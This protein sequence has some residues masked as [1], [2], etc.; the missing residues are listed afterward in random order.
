MSSNHYSKSHI[1]QV[2]KMIVPILIVAAIGLAIADVFGADSFI[3][4]MFFKKVVFTPYNIVGIILFFLFLG[5]TWVGKG[6]AKVMFGVATV[7]SIMPTLIKINNFLQ[8]D[9]AAKIFDF[10]AIALIVV[11]GLLFIIPIIVVIAESICESKEEKKQK[12]KFIAKK[13]NSLSDEDLMKHIS[14]NVENKKQQTSNS[15]VKQN[16]SLGNTQL[17]QNTNY[18]TSCIRDSD[19]WKIANRICPRCGAKL[20]ARTNGHDGTHFLGCTK[21]GKTGCD[22]TINY[23][24]Y[25]AIQERL[26]IK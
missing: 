17:I 6:K 1:E 12:D 14:S 21:Y 19:D 3:T 20:C 18:R 4:T 25:Y 15:I 23:V 22:F 26:G 13:P 9:L 7:L 11:V 5:G 10:V 2:T 16:N 24:D 8:S